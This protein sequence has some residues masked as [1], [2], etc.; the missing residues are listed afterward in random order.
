MRYKSFRLGVING[1]LFEVVIATMQPG[2]VLS[3]FFFK[4][5]DSTFYAALP[6][7]LMYLGG[8]WPPLIV[9]HIAEGMERKKTD[10]HLRR[11]D[12]GTLWGCVVFSAVSSDW[13]PASTS[14][15]CSAP[16]D[17]PSR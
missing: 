11:R 12:A 1:A 8:L 15:T 17:H 10:L 16:T 2:L 13:L 4:L 3:A 7:T 5:T 14:S 6:M 9:A